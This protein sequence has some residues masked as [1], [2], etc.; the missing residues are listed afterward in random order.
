MSKVNFLKLEYRLE[1]K[2]QDS[3]CGIVDG[4]DAAP[5]F[6]TTEKDIKWNAT[7]LN[8]KGH[9]FQ[10]VPVD[11]N[12]IILKENRHDKESTCDGML[13]VDESNM[14]A[15]IELKDVKTGGMADAISQL[16]NT[17][18]HF[19]SNHRYEIFRIRRA[20]AAN[21]AHP[22][23][24]YNMKDEIERFRALKFVLFPEATIRL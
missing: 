18:K 19:L 6:A 2:R 23:F 12:I 22:Q 8:P 24:H 3:E 15:F 4:P 17:I 9:S 1:P 14:I 21:I 16:E 10:F 20:Y 13:L 7:I 11:N 5:A